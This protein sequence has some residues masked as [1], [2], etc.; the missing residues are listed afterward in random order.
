MQ[1]SQ[2]IWCVMWERISQNWT[3]GLT[4]IHKLILALGENL[5]E[6]V[7]TQ[8][9]FESLFMGIVSWYKLMDEPDVFVTNVELY[10]IIRIKFVYE[11]N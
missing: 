8:A 1:T 10:K 9:V 2:V 3:V 11:N 7:K 4:W 6:N 5:W